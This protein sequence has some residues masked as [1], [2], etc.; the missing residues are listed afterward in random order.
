M[1]HPELIGLLAIALLLRL[2]CVPWG[3]PS[4]TGTLSSNHPDETYTF[5]ALE[6]MKSTHSLHPG[7]GLLYGSLHTYMTGALLGAAMVT[8]FVHPGSRDYL[9]DHPEMLDRMYLTA[10]LFSVLAGLLSL[11]VLFVLAR[12]WAGRRTAFF[13]AFVL[14]F[15]P[16]AII[17]N[18]YIK[19]ECLLLF[20]IALI[21][22]SAQRYLA[23]REPRGLV[24]TGAL[25]G[26]AAATKYTGGIFILALPVLLWLGNGSFKSLLGG[27]LAS[28]VFFLIGN[29]YALLDFP[30][31]RAAL[32][33]QSGMAVNAPLWE[34]GQGNGFW[35][36]ASYYV[37]FA[38][39]WG[40]WLISLVGVFLLIRKREDNFARFVAMMA[41][42]S[43][44]AAAI[45]P[46]RF[47]GYT[48]PMLP[49]IVLAGAYAL[50]WFWTEVRGGSWLVCVVLATQAA[51]AA[52][53]VSLARP[54]DPRTQASQWL[55]THVPKGTSVGIFKSYFWTP[56]ILRQRN[57][58]F[59]VMRASEDQDALGTGQTRFKSLKPLPRWWVVS[60]L[61]TR[62]YLR[63]P[64]WYPEQA[65]GIRALFDTYEV[66]A[67]FSKPVPFGRW[68][69]WRRPLPWDYRYLAP[70]IDIL[71]IK[72]N[73]SHD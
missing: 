38:V 18:S 11:C 29:P 45:P 26:L 54:P 50:N 47:V 14:A 23:K 21:A 68:R 1:K 63:S 52:G 51:F 16:G 55:Q 53:F 35:R 59:Q 66:K 36:M 64:T 31:F 30:S 56:A 13:A 60:E 34:I 65:A 44:L 28:A 57:S 2:A 25:I 40:P 17:Y 42:M 19:V 49:W 27:I 72:E 37:P 20:W 15:A 43:F 61:E 10:R 39:G 46:T 33:Q 9:L 22:A 5:L 7:L 3:L 71:H 4:Q 73:G 62:E 24:V 58:P 69:Q 67:S 8:G 6:H 70:S 41:L 48:I 12:R 32:V